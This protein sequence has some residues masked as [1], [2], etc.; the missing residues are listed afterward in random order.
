MP[1]RYRF[2]GENFVEYGRHVGLFPG[3]NEWF[4][5]INV[6]AGNNISL[7]S[8]IVSSGLREMVARVSRCEEVRTYLLASAFAY[9]VHGVAYAPALALNYNNQDAVPLRINKGT[10]DVW[11]N[12]SD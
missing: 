7:S 8:T 12:R 6:T 9:D 11:D 2:A 4:D 10:L 3:V 5:R 1:N